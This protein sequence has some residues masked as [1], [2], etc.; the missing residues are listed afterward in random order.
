MQNETEKNMKHEINTGDT[1]VI[2]WLV[3]RQ[4]VERKKEAIIAFRLWGLGLTGVKRRTVT[5]G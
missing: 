1:G 2:W 5:E 3:V 4:G